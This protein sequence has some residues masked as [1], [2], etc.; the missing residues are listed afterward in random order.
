MTTGGAGDGAERAARA[1]A[2]LRISPVAA[3]DVERLGEMF[4]RL[5]A[6]TGVHTLG[7]DG[8]TASYAITTSSMSGLLTELGQVAATIGAAVTRTIGGEIA[9]ALP[10]DQAPVLTPDAAPAEPEPIPAGEDA[11]PAAAQPSTEAPARAPAKPGGRDRKRRP[12]LRAVPHPDEPRTSPVSRIRDRL[13]AWR[14]RQARV[15]ARGGRSWNALLGVVVFA[16]I[17]A[18]SLT[19]SEQCSDG[20]SSAPANRDTVGAGRYAPVA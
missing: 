3:A 16:A 15:H 17:I 20:G 4:A 12:R 8:E 13:A 2:R 1:E 5:P 14:Q 6:V 11:P 7:L 9:F 18:L 10:S 19:V